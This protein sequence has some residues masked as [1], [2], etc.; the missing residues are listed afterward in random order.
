MS[1]EASRLM[2]EVLERELQ[3]RSSDRWKMPPPI[4]FQSPLEKYEEGLR[5][6][7]EL[8][9]LE[10]QRERFQE[11]RRAAPRPQ[12]PTETPVVSVVEK[13][14]I[15]DPLPEKDSYDPTRAFAKRKWRLQLRAAQL[16]YRM[17]DLDTEYKR[18][19]K[20][21]IIWRKHARCCQKL[22]EQANATELEAAKEFRQKRSYLL[23]PA[24][25]SVNSTQGNLNMD[26]ELSD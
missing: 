6:L 13:L 20:F 10:T 11:R 21:C 19:L 15:E 22:C 7:E 1:D 25:R 9:I 4:T 17:E 8:I 14:F 24:M 16:R 12:P 2:I 23:K 5:F 3:W 18:S 26:T